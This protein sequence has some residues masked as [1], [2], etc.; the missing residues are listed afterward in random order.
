MTRPYRSLWLALLPL[1]ALLGCGSTSTQH[2]AG[3]LEFLYPEGKEA[4]LPTDVRLEL[5]LRVGIAFVPE[6]GGSFRSALDEVQKVDLLERVAQAFREEEG[7]AGIEVIP[8]T[9]LTPGGGFENVDQLRTLF[10]IDLV[11]LVSYDQRQFDEMS[12]SS[13]TYWTIVGAYIVPGNVNDTSTFLDTSVFDVR[14]RALLFNAAGRNEVHGR[15]TGIESPQALRRASA[16]GFDLAV[17]DMLVE[18]ESTL[19]GFREHVKSGTLRGP[20]TPAIQVTDSREGSGGGTGVGFVAPVELGAVALLATLLL[21]RRRR[22][23]A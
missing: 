3:V 11:A 18:L 13:I 17:D 10:G 21:T 9:Y 15:S 7:I 12:K 20:G 4:S 2:R 22:R 8:S 16:E 14:S 6:S 1:L 23:G 5:P 19:E